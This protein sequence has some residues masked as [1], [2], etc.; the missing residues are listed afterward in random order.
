M[1]HFAFNIDNLCLW[2]KTIHCWLPPG[3]W[4]VVSVFKSVSQC[5]PLTG[6]THSNVSIF[7]FFFLMKLRSLITR[8]M[9]P[10][11]NHLLTWNGR[12]VPPC[13]SNHFIFVESTLHKLLC[14]HSVPQ[15]LSP[16]GGSLEKWFQGAS[17]YPRG[18][19]LPCTYLSSACTAKTKISQS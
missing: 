7:F 18:R 2:R 6:P 16:H 3:L 12:P 8:K 14:P 4:F 15:S 5:W 17:T 13:T 1:F 9:L 19:S 10:C 11:V